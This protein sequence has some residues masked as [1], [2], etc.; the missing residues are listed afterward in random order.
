[1]KVSLSIIF[2]VQPDELQIGEIDFRG[3]IYKKR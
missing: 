2:S 3:D 1:M